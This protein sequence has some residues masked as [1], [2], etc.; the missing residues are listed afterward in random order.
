MGPEANTRE[1]LALIFRCLLHP[2]QPL[3]EETWGHKW[4]LPETLPS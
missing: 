2:W 1:V 3:P 4:C